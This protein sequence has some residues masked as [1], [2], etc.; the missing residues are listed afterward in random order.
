MAET[1]KIATGTGREFKLSVSLSRWVSSPSPHTAL[2]RAMGP[3]VG[4][5]TPTPRKCD[6]RGREV[7]E[8]NTF[9]CGFCEKPFTLDSR[10][11]RYTATERADDGTAV[12]AKPIGGL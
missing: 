1:R 2:P 6:D 10:D 9:I 12:D 3:G 11:N 4:R 5:H 8:T 7:T